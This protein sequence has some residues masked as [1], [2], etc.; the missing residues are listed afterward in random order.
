MEKTEAKQIEK[1]EVTGQNEKTLQEHLPWPWGKGHFWKEMKH[2]NRSRA[3]AQGEGVCSERREQNV[4]KPQRETMPCTFKE[5]R[6][7]EHA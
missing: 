6:E 7:V 3:R 4:Q 2:I 1:E 5:M